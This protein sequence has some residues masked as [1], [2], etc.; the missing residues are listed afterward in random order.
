MAAALL[1]F[2]ALAALPSEAQRIAL[3]AAASS[4]APRAAA[5]PSPC[6]SAENRRAKE[7]KFEA[8]QEARVNND[9]A[10][11]I[12]LVEV[13]LADRCLS[14]KD[15]RFSMLIRIGV[16]AACNDKQRDKTRELYSRRPDPSLISVCRQFLSD[17]K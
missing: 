11:T 1:A 9:D 3:A 15:R 17:L 10:E 2:A 13:A 7:E 12:R 14:P 16:I 4:K 5:K 8:V 6:S